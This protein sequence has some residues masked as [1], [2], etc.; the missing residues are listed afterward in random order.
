MKNDIILRT[1]VLFML[2]FIMLYAFYVQIHGDYSP[3]GGFQGG[4]IFASSMII[5]LLI[6]PGSIKISTKLLQLLAALGVLFI[7]A[8]S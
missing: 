4:V 1:V 5:Y 6:F 8:L 7:T 3:G 2:P